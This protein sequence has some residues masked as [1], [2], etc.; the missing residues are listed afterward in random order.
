MRKELDVV[1]LYASLFTRIKCRRPMEC[2]A[3][4]Q[5]NDYV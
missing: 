4:V 3:R 5:R 2:I 1:A